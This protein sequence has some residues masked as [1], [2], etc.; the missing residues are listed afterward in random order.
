MDTGLPGSHAA[1]EVT[2]VLADMSKRR[3]AGDGDASDE[4][5]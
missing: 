4:K 1:A 5:P 2:R 3:G